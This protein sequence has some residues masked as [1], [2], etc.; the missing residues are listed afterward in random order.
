MITRCL[1]ARWPVGCRLRYVASTGVVADKTLCPF[2][3]TAYRVPSLDR[4]TVGSYW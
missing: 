1:P 2:A 4:A 3:V